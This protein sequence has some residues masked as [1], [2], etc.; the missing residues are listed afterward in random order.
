MFLPPKKHTLYIL[1]P[2]Y[3]LVVFFIGGII[4]KREKNL[5]MAWIEKIGGIYYLRESVKEKGRWKSTTIASFGKQQP[6]LWYPQLINDKAENIITKIPDESI[7]LIVTDPPYGIGFKGNRYRNIDFEE[8]FNDQSLQ[9]LSVFSHEF[10]RILVPQAHCY[11][12]TRWD[13]Y[14]IMLK[15][16]TDSLFLQTVIIWDKDEG[17]HGMGDLKQWAPRYEMIMD[18]TKGDTPRPLNGKRLPNIIRHKD[19][20]FTGEP[21]IHPTQKPRGLMEILI[22]KSSDWGDVV[23]DFFGGSY[24]VPRAAMRTWRKSI[25]VE[26][27]PTVHN[28]ALNLVEREFHNDPEYGVDWA[29]VTNLDVKKTEVV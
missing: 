9:F 24:P 17:G 1:L 11:I 29:K 14:P 18:F 7:N 15:L 16:F 8:M 3:L 20:R 4:Y 10:E 2:Q 23:A 12:F 21:K 5:G 6:I 13:V 26:L 22:E 27:N 25:G 19:I 28:A